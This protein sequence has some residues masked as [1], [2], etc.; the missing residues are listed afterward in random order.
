MFAFLQSGFLSAAEKEGDVSIFLGFGNAQLCL[1]AVGQHFSRLSSSVS[2]G[3]A[4]GQDR[5]AAYSVSRPTGCWYR[6]AGKP[7]KGRVYQC[8]RELSRSIGAKVHEQHSIAVSDEGRIPVPV[9]A[10][11]SSSSPLA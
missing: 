6:A 9:G 4:T 5:L 8:L 3:K 2:G 1:A 7:R 11:N 10:T